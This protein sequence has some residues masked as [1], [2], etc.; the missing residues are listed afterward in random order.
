MKVL[1]DTSAIMA[2]LDADDANHAG[3]REVWRDLLDRDAI[4]LC[5]NYVLLEAFA[6]VQHRLGMEA[7]RTLQSDVVPILMTQWVD[8]SVHGT[9][10]AAL[11]T[12]RRRKLSLVD[13]V[14]FEIARRLGVSIAFAFDRHFTEQ[15]L[16]C[17]PARR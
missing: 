2:V 4:L 8:E 12:A 10:V 5:T 16:Q 6:L 3:A 14:S 7:L 13:C 17:L 1:V 9:A 15:G 11:L